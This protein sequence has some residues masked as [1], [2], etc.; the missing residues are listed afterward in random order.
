MK[1]KNKFTNF[2]D[3]AKKTM[4]EKDFNEAKAE[5]KAIA[6]LLDLASARKGLG[7]IQSEIEGYTQSEIS[8]IEGRS[9]I[10]VSTLLAYLKSMG[11]KVKITGVDPKTK[12]E[13]EL[14]KGA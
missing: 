6:A 11:L 3:E 14:I 5:G 1:K 8:R 13:Y 9:D 10:K 2:F 7:K 12:E 4:S